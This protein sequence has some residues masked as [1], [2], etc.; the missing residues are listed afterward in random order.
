MKQGCGTRRRSL[1]CAPVRHPGAVLVRRCR[2]AAH[3]CGEGALGYAP[4]ATPGVSQRIG[5]DIHEGVGRAIYLI[6]QSTEK[7]IFRSSFS[8][9]YVHVYTVCIYIYIDT[10]TIYVYVYVYTSCRYIDQ[11]LLWFDLVLQVAST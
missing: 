6:L 3:G 5:S 1:H 7:H 9:M 2:A 10:H 4:D 11:L 8:I